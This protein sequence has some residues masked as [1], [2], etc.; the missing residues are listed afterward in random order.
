LA[1]IS[2]VKRGQAI[3]IKTISELLLKIN[4][5]RND[6]RSAFTSALAG[7]DR[8]FKDGFHTM[9]VTIKNGRYRLIIGSAMQDLVSD[10]K[11]H[12]QVGIILCHE[13]VHIV[14][15]HVVEV[16]HL[17]SEMETDEEKSLASKII[18]FS[19]DYAANSV[20]EEFKFWSRDQF[21]KSHP[22]TEDGASGKY[23]GVLP[24]DMGLEFHLSFREYFDI[25]WDMM[26]NDK[27]PEGWEGMPG[28]EGDPSD[29]MSDKVKEAQDYINQMGKA[30]EQTSPYGHILDVSNLEGLAPEELDEL[31]KIAE[32]ASETIKQEV[33]DTMRRR[34]FGSSSVVNSI[35]KSLEG[36]TKDWRELLSEFCLD[37]KNNGDDPLSTN[38]KPSLAML[39]IC[40]KSKYRLTPYPG[41]KKK[42]VWTIG[43]F[44]DS[45]ASVTDSELGGFLAE[46]DGL[47]EAGTELLL[48][49]CDSSITHVEEVCVGDEMSPL[50][51]GRGGTRFEPPFEYCIENNK[52]VDMVIYFTDGGAS[53]PSESSQLNVPVLWCVTA[54]GVVP[55]SW[56]P[57]PSG[58]YLELDYGT[59]ITLG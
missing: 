50:I 15:G 11:N 45:S 19:V 58:D 28:R 29:E 53:L 38:M 49:H 48:I 12:V 2:L 56:T 1:R 4:N 23:R 54:G 47:L 10:T 36:P 31:A 57:M 52:E 8:E 21:V 9:A 41:R 55:G 39:D 42:P 35:A 5:T 20:G 14:Q 18:P 32:M 33:V 43:V 59:A 25:L 51:Y 44:I 37:A 6:L 13:L 16:I 46:I 22:L 7:L 17:Y 34:G 30:G 3:S 26:E 27:A 40:R 24:S